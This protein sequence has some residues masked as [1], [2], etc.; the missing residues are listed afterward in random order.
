M[1]PHSFLV[2]QLVYLP[3]SPSLFLSISSLSPSL[4][5]PLSLSL[6]SSVSPPVSPSPSFSFSLSL[7]SL[8]LFLS[9]LFI[10][11]PVSPSLS[12]ILS[13]SLSRSLSLSPA[14][15]LSPP[16]LS[17]LY[18]AFMYV[19]FR[20][21]TGSLSGENNILVTL[22]VVATLRLVDIFATGF[23]QYGKTPLLCTQTDS[24]LELPTSIRP[25]RR[26]KGVRG[27]L[28]DEDDRYI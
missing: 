3:L 24:Y 16:P 9:L 27:A 21:L 10:S 15:S 22:A 25:K 19:T 1:Y 20:R 17:L 23:K 18:L 12:P 26:Q 5:P 11:H 6:S 2:Y 13:P 14:L 28:D 4:S 8:S 7:L